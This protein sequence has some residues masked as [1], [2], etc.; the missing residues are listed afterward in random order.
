MR[1]GSTITISFYAIII[2]LMG[3]RRANGI[4]STLD[5]THS[6]ICQS[7]AGSRALS[8]NKVAEIVQEQNAIALESEERTLE[9]EGLN[10]KAALKKAARELGLKRDEAYRLMLTQKNRRSK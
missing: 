1:E 6:V 5:I 7:P 4:I 2:Y 9:D 10:E 8:W 3:F